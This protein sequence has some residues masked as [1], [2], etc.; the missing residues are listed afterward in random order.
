MVQKALALTQTSLEEA[1]RSVLDLRAAPLAGRN[2]AEAIEALIQEWSGQDSLQIHYRTTGGS[3][4]LPTRIEVGLYRI[5]QEGLTNI[6]RHAGAQQVNLELAV[7]PAQVRL[8]IEDDGRGFDPEQVPA[9]HFGLIGL[10]ER[11]KLL[12]GQLKL[13]SSTGAGVRVEVLV[14]LNGEATNE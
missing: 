12:G 1:R 4:P 11:V 14:P 2:L 10:N 5:V 3:Q 7:T 13:E 6:A 8:V 9:G